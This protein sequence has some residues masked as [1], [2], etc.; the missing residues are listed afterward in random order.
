MSFFMV[1]LIVFTSPSIDYSPSKQSLPFLPKSP[2]C[3]KP[4][5]LAKVIAKNGRCVIGRV[6]Y[7]G[8][9]VSTS[10]ANEYP[11]NGTFIGL[12]LPNKIGDCDGSFENRKFFEW[13]AIFL[14]RFFS[15]LFFENLFMMMLIGVF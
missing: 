3:L 12:Q 4:G 1:V 15:N 13:Y 11:D 14:H 8:P 9:L 5:H 7:I 10:A 6:R 2:N